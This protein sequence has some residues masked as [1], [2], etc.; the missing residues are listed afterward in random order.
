M[1]SLNYKHLRYFLEVARQGNLTRAA[2]MLGVAQSALSTQIHTL[3]ER[4]GHHLFER[5]GR[6]L[7]CRR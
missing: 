5:V 4:L 6:H 2:R 1:N 3:E 7:C